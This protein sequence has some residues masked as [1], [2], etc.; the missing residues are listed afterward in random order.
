MAYRTKP[1][2][3]IPPPPV[4]GAKW[5]PLTKG[6]FA[7]IDDIDYAAVSKYNWSVFQGPLNKTVYAKCYL[8]TGKYRKRGT[9]GSET[10]YSVRQVYLHKFIWQQ[11]RRKKTLLDHKDRNGLNNRRDNLRAATGVQNKGNIG[12]NAA[13]T[14]G[15]RGVMWAKQKGKWKATLCHRPKVKHLGFFLNKEDAARAYDKAAAEY[16]GEFAYL[17]FPDAKAS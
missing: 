17:N 16:F 12:L 6:L 10:G 1:R 11:M 4:E 3:A 2:V 7:L 8:R 13:N 15:Y 14:S 5:I 9:V